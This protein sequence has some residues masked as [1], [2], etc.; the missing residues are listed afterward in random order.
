MMKKTSLLVRKN[1]SS[2]GTQNNIDSISMILFEIALNV[3][4]LV[5]DKSVFDPIMDLHV[6]SN[7]YGAYMAVE[8]ILNK[9]DDLIKNVPSERLFEIIRLVASYKNN[10]K[11]H[12]DVL[13]SE[14]NIRDVI[15][16]NPRLYL[17]EAIAKLKKADWR[18]SNIGSFINFPTE[19][20]SILFEQKMYANWLFI[21][22]PCIERD[23]LKKSIESL[24]KSKNEIINKIGICL[25]GL[26]LNGFQDIF[27]DRINIFFTHKQYA[28]DLIQLLKN[29]SEY[30]RENNAIK[31]AIEERLGNSDFGYKDSIYKETITKAI[32]NSLTS[33]DSRFQMFDLTETEMEILFY[34]DSS[35]SFY[36]VDTE[37]EVV[38]IYKSIKDKD[39]DEVITYVN[40]SSRGQSLYFDSSLKK[41]L[42]KYFKEKDFSTYKDRI[43]ELGVSYLLSYM[44]NTDYV[45]IN[46]DGIKKLIYLLNQL[47]DSQ[48]KEAMMTILFTCQ[49]MIIST[50][51][52]KNYKE[53]LINNIDYKLIEIKEED[54]E[55]KIGNV[56][57]TSLHLYWSVLYDFTKIDEKL[58][59]HT[60]LQS[61]HYFYK[62]YSKYPLFK[63]ITAS[64]FA[65]IYY[66]ESKKTREDYFEYV[67][68]KENCETSYRVFSYV[69]GTNYYL[70]KLCELDSF[71]S[72][73]LNKDDASQERVKLA[74]RVILMYLFENELEKTFKGIINNG[75]TEAIE[76]SFYKIENNS[77]LFIEGDYKKRFDD[78]I[79]GCIK[80]LNKITR[81][82]FSINQIFHFLVDIMIKEKDQNLDKLWN[83]LILLPKGFSYYHGDSIIKLIT[84]FGNS[85]SNGCKKLL[86]SL[87]NSYDSTYIPDYFLVDLFTF[88]K[89]YNVFSNDTKRWITIIGEKTPSVY[90]KLTTIVI[91]SE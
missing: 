69:N 64:W 20:N 89:E 5:N 91:K 55:I 34:I 10:D 30:I 56:I 46:N 65:F 68:N 47:T 66:Y 86:D 60:L 27:L 17:E 6:A 32:S 2:C 74:S 42:D 78:F 62:N 28:A 67:F 79:D 8:D 26:R 90:E 61:F 81:R 82:T 76:H 13:S 49:K 73:L 14:D 59:S 18:F 71:N 58:A 7:Q 4:E 57:N 75:D 77:D 41:A 24:L 15:F 70:I 80:S 53:G 12:Y 44:C 43:K 51:V 21:A 88:L 22:T 72:F 11:E 1:K 39:I 33:V 40:E 31:D 19:N 29:N 16:T 50:D 52:D 36:S 83:L 48:K 9:K 25:I 54:E 3:I 45:Q 23:S 87:F 35:A 85:N 63:A 37:K 84:T 38:S